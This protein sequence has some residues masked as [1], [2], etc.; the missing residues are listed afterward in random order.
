MQHIPADMKS[1]THIHQWT[2]G[3]AFSQRRC[4]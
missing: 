2:P 1:P 3:T 4:T